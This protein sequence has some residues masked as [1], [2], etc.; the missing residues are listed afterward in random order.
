MNLYNLP[1]GPHLVKSDVSTHLQ[2]FSMTD[3]RVSKLDKYPIPKID[4]LFME[5]TGSERYVAGLPADH[6]GQKF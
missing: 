1:S 2:G 6:F 3:N 5:L 4:D